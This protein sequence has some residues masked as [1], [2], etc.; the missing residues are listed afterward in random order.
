MNNKSATI[1][2]RLLVRSL[3]ALIFTVHWENVPLTYSKPK[4]SF[5]TALVKPLHYEPPM[6]FERNV[7]KKIF[8][9]C[10][11]L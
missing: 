8:H 4:P 10:P 5:I 11:I 6:V 2:N 9:F 3:R 1:C 7:K